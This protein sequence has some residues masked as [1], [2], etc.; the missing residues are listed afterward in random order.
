MRNYRAQN[1]AYVTR[2][3]RIAKARRKAMERLAKLHETEFAALYQ[4]E[5]EA[6]GVA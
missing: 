5:R 6:E 3:R 4:E 1:Q 2:Q